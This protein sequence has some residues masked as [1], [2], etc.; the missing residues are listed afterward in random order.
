MKRTKT[1]EKKVDLFLDSGAFSALTQGVE[2]D[3]QEY[4][5]F[6]KEHEDV[7]DIYANLDVIG[8]AEG[9]WKNQITMEKAGLNPMP[10]YHYGED[11]KWL[12]RYLKRGYDYIA[13][14]GLV[15]AS[16]SALKSWLDPIWKDYLTTDD[17][18]PIIKVHGFGL[19]S[20]TL[21]KRYPWYSVDSTSWVVTGR[22]GSIM[23]PLPDHSNGGWDYMKNPLKVDVSSQSP[24]SVSSMKKNSPNARDAKPIHITNLKPAGAREYALKYIKDKGYKLGKSE[25]RMESQDYELK[26]NEKWADKKPKDKKTKR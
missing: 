25:F 8:S 7:I 17:G 26:E 2:I 18:M 11:V 4:I 15:G 19:T 9:T 3:I 24:N 20:L 12:K 21:M 22:M 10:V 16:S 23:I 13:L 6:I 14:G 1:N 5:K